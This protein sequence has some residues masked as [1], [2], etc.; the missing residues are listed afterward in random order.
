MRA[1]AWLRLCAGAHAAASCTVDGSGNSRQR[2]QQQR[3]GFLFLYPRHGALAPATLDGD[4][5]ARRGWMRRKGG[6]A[7]PAGVLVGHAQQGL[8]RASSSAPTMP[9]TRMRRVRF[10]RPPPE[11][12]G[13][14][15]FHVHT[16]RADS[17]PRAAHA[18]AARPTMCGL[19]LRHFGRAP[20]RGVAIAS[21]RLPL[22]GPARVRLPSTHVM[23][24]AYGSSA[25]PSACDHMAPRPGARVLPVAVDTQATEITSVSRMGPAPPRAPHFAGSWDCGAGH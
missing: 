18:C 3:S 17:L 2:Q 14:Y 15:S 8:Q 25:N 11:I 6:V 19:S 7:P 22:D 16:Q 9:W 10:F 1:G 4:R 20:A 12:C 21:V 5:A 13:F 24:A 23:R